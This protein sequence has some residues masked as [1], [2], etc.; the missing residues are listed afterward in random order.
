LKPES[1][2]IVGA[3]RLAGNCLEACLEHSLP[4]QCLETEHQAFSPLAAQSRKRGIEYRQ[5]LEPGALTSFFL[6]VQAPALVVSCFNYYIFPSNVLANQALNVVNFHNS[7][8][9]R[10][11]GR[12]AATWAIF[13]QDKEAGITWHQVKPKVDTGEV[14]TERPIPIGAD[15]TAMDLTA[16]MLAAAAQAFRDILPGLLAGAYSAQTVSRTDG[17]SYHRSTEVP[18]GGWLDTS[19]DV[20]QAYAFMR[21]LDYGKFK[22][23]PNPRVRWSGK[24]MVISGYRMERQASGRGERDTVEF[25][26]NTLVLRSP[27]ADLL[28]T[29][30][31]A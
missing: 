2:I 5:V 23:F 22:V 14:I 10:H 12:N 13:S 18:N 30:E 29:C 25:K 27:G 26:D 21:S 20:N 15:T 1:I 19:W 4:V 7:L 11:R 24:E 28:L 6:G 3:G 17:A 16:Q 9:P 8:F 31:A